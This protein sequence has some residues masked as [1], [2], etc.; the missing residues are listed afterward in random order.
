MSSD[1]K[2]GE[3]RGDMSDEFDMVD[4]LLAGPAGRLDAEEKYAEG[5]NDRPRL[6]IIL[7]FNLTDGR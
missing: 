6:A 5:L 3:E 2:S 7:S 4:K 1:R